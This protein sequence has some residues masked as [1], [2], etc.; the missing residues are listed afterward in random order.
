MKGKGIIGK[1]IERGKITKEEGKQI[2]GFIF[3]ASGT[4]FAVGI[5]FGMTIAILVL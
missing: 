4:A 1:L 3:S 5:L 2:K